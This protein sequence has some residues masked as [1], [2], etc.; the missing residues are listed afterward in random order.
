MKRVIESEMFAKPRVPLIALLALSL[1]LIGDDVLRT[2]VWLN[3]IPCSC[4]LHYSSL[5]L[6]YLSTDLCVNKNRLL[7]SDL[8]QYIRAFIFAAQNDA[9]F[10]QQRATL[11]VT[12]FKFISDETFGIGRDVL[13]RSLTAVYA[14]R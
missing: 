14:I 12:Y 3:I 9:V 10:T 1:T 5:T 7:A 4:F 8:Q 2:N 11:S 13:G 6:L